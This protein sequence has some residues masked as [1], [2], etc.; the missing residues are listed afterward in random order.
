[1]VIFN[2]YHVF[3][4]FMKLCGCRFLYFF[5]LC[6]IRIEVVFLI[7]EHSSPR[8]VKQKKH[9]KKQILVFKPLLQEIKLKNMTVSRRKL[10]WSTLWNKKNACCW[11]L[12][13]WSEIE[14]YSPPS[15]VFIKNLQ[16]IHLRESHMKFMEKNKV[17]NTTSA[18]LCSLIG[19]KWRN[20][21]QKT[22]NNYLSDQASRHLASSFPFSDF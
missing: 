2:I 3:A 16:L 4:P 10:F 5:S 21:F 8:E 22:L 14:L 6:D 7:L 9:K 15:Y 12:Q 1:M 13:K 18:K 11:N 17:S 19:Q 20:S